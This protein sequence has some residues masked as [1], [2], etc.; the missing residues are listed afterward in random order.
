M[1]STSHIKIT[2]ISETMLTDVTLCLNSIAPS[3]SKI[4]IVR[5]RGSLSF[6]PNT[7]LVCLGNLYPEETAYLYYTLG[8]DTPT[9]PIPAFTNQ[10]MQVIFTP[11][12]KEIVTT[13]SKTFL[14]FEHVDC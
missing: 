5:E 6:G 10:N 7:E 8:S 12:G 14:H 9:P 4:L 11:E 3:L 13:N 1:S 2:N